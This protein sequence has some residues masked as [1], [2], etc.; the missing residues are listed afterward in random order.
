[1]E[2]I[3]NTAKARLIAFYLPQF[4]PIP[5]NDKWWGKG[6]TEWTNVTK[7]KPLFKGHKQPKLPSELGFYDLRIPEVRTQQADL[8][9][10]HGIEGFCY[11]HYWFGKGKKILDRPFNE[12]VTSGSPDFPFCLA[13]AN[14]SWEGTW[15]GGSNGVLFK[16]TYPGILDYEDHFYSLLPAFE[17]NRYIKI[18]GKILFTVML[19][20]SVPDFDKFVETWENLAVKNG[21]SGFYFNGFQNGDKTLKSGLNSALNYGGTPRSIYNAVTHP[22]KYRFLNNPRIRKILNRP[23]IV[24]Y[25]DFINAALPEINSFQYPNFPVIYANWD[26]TPRASTDG[27][28]FTHFSLDLFRKYL[29]RAID[30]VSKYDFEEKVIFI[31]SWNEWAEGNYLEPDQEFGRAYLEVIRDELNNYNKLT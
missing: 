16:Q 29:L 17:D 26:N 30:Y 6:F 2:I 13:W 10:S 5:E 4:H 14:T 15:Y 8:A 20:N 9:R 11:W 18:D 25:G 31:K 7:A 21:L 24:R 1:M 23:K 3:H 12:V 27:V 22:L 28:V 19:P